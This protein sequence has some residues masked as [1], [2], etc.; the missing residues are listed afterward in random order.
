L[1][2][3]QQQVI[4]LLALFLLSIIQRHHK[5]ALEVA[6]C[7]NVALVAPLDSLH[8]TPIKREHRRVRTSVKYCLVIMEVLS[9]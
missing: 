9:G 6:L 2:H 3:L 5:A 4:V 8:G 7:G 1:L